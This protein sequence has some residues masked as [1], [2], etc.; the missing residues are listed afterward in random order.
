[1]TER[2]NQLLQFV[3]DL[4]NGKYDHII[5]HNYKNWTMRMKAYNPEYRRA[6]NREYHSKYYQLNYKSLLNRKTLW[7]KILHREEKIYHVN[8]A[9]NK[10]GRD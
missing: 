7:A 6:Y 9:K 4:R 5:E 10:A 1:M 3:S 8:I 2:E